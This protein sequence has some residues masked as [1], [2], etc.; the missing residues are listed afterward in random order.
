M[1]QWCKTLRLCSTY[2]T[3]TDRTYKVCTV[4]KVTVIEL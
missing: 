3:Q 4:I 2:L 1:E